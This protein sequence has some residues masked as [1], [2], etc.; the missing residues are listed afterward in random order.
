MKMKLLKLND[1]GAEI[2]STYLKE[3][4]HGQQRNL[5]SYYL[6]HLICDALNLLLWKTFK[7]LVQAVRSATFTTLFGVVLLL[8]VTFLNQEVTENVENRFSKGHHSSIHNENLQL[9]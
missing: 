8:V 5:W 6:L 4:L 9:L 2:T 1:L 7:V 3:L